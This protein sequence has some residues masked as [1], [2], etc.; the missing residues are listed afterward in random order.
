LPLP[1]LSLPAF[2]KALTPPRDF[3]L[4]WDHRYALRPAGKPACRIRPI[5]L[6]SPLPSSCGLPAA[7]HR[8]RIATFPE[9]CCVPVFRQDFPGR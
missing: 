2:S 3:C 6:R 1:R 5:S 7:D 4:P 8:S 9:A